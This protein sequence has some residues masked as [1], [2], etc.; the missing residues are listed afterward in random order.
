LRRGKP[1]CPVLVAVSGLLLLLSAL[2]RFGTKG[3]RVGGGGGAATGPL[4]APVTC[5]RK[6]LLLGSPFRCS[7]PTAMQPLYSTSRPVG[8]SSTIR[9][10]CS[11]DTAERAGSV[12]MPSTFSAVGLYWTSVSRKARACRKQMY[13]L[14]TR[15]VCRKAPVAISPSPYLHVEPGGL[16]PGPP[17][18]LP[19]TVHTCSRQYWG[20]SGSLRGSCCSG[21]RP[22][23]S[24]PDRTSSA[25]RDACSENGLFGSWND[26]NR[27]ETDALAPS[28]EA[29]AR[30]PPI[31]LVP[32]T[33][34]WYSPLASPVC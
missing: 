27:D 1:S 32:A 6:Q 33:E 34:P 28:L 2:G 21:A 18:P 5:A 31:V 3:G 30:P 22:C 13:V 25:S 7:L 11:R 14:P 9:L 24:S 15:S 19:P 29:P 8:S 4:A 12:L 10:T 17:A 20:A 26:P 23:R 16:P